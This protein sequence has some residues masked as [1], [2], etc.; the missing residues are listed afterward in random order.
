MNH[1]E[2]TLVSSRQLAPAVRHYTFVR[3]DGGPMRFTPGQFVQVHFEHEGALLRRS[4]SIA[5][6]AGEGSAGEVE[7]AVSFIPGGAAS[8][9]FEHLQPTYVL[10]CP[11]RIAG[12]RVR[13]TLQFPVFD[14]RVGQSPHGISQRMRCPPECVQHVVAS[15]I[16]VTQGNF[17]GRVAVRSFPRALGVDAR[18]YRHPLS[19]PCLGLRGKR[20]VVSCYE[21]P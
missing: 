11:L 17:I 8:T 12:A 13:S 7:L 9:L 15:L 18:S 4:Y 19:L 6:P 3:S 2:L 14:R 5:T 1:F 20:R 10:A 16:G 21:A